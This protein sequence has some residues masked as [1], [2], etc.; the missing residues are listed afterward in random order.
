MR[1][2]RLSGKVNPLIRPIVSILEKLSAID[3]VEATYRSIPIIDD[4]KIFIDETLETLR[5]SWSIEGEGRENIPGEGPLLVVANHPFG[6]IEGLILGSLLMSIRPD[7]KILGNYL[8]R[9]IRELEKVIIGVDPFNR[10][11]SPIR[12]AVPLRT[13]LQWL[14]EGGALV[15][16]AAGA[17]S[18]LSIKNMRV[19]DPAWNPIVA[20]LALKSEASVLPVFFHG[21][22]RAVFHI[23]GI[24]HPKIRTLLL[25][26]ELESKKG[27]KIRVTVGKLLSFRE[28]S[29]LSFPETIIEYFRMKTYL[30]G[31]KPGENK[32]RIL[33]LPKLVKSP[34]RRENSI[35]ESLDPELLRREIESLPQENILLTSGSFMVVCSKAGN[36]P[37]ILREIGRLR[38]ISFRAV[39]EGTLKKL[40]LDRFDNHYDHLFIWHL[41]RSE[42]VGAYRL[43][44][45]DTILNTYGIDGFYTSMLFRY[46][47][48]LLEVLTKSVELGRSFIRPEY[49]RHQTALW[50]LWKGIGK[51]ITCHSNGKFLF[52]PVS[53]SN[54]YHPFSK[55]LMVTFLKYRFLEEKLSSMVFPRHPWREKTSPPWN[56]EKLC[57]GLQDMDVLDRIIMQIEKNERGIPVLLKHYL[58]LGGRVAGFNIDRNFS[59]A[60]DVLV[61]VDLSKARLPIIEKAIGRKSA[62]LLTEAV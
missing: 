41:E 49:Q 40:D 38:E 56:T 28:Y 37:N 23:L 19:V 31:L 58:K 10:A 12:N 6:G 43:G 14:T 35:S 39:G 34:G 11:D 1:T 61:F 22:N 42:V 33:S 44:K 25:P 55:L 26:R 2:L 9:N 62:R 21:N 29:S 60:L 54:V 20:K 7:V 4:P 32:V 45:G 24:L 48:G 47:P 16:F 57:A 46:S 15:V 5:I 50:L 13:A 27:H 8:L 59:R 17:V 51:Y 53:I 30:L 18:H 52:G 3:K 36:I